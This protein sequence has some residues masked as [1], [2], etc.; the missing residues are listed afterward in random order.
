[1][2]LPYA[3]Q[4]VV[5]P[6]KVSDYLLSLTHPEGR[7]KARFFLDYGFRENNPSE[8]VLALLDR[9]LK[10]EASLSK[11]NKFSRIYLVE[12]PVWSPDGRNPR[13]RTIWI[14]ET[15]S[16]LPRLITAYPTP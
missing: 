8:L 7:A 16:T 6:N 15:E 3:E 13:L 11:E 9:A 1:V 10:N 2:R 4:A 14:I 5:Y 12:G